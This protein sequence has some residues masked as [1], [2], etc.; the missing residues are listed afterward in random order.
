LFFESLIWVLFFC[1][2]FAAKTCGIENEVSHRPTSGD[3]PALL[4][5]HIILP[6]GSTLFIAHSLE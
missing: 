3:E 6:R 1:K 4:F 5:R 2:D